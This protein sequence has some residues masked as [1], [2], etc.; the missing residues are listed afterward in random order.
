[1]NSS[2]ERHRNSISP[3]E[4]EKYRPRS[5]PEPEH[6]K[7][8]KEEKDCHG[9]DGE[10]SD[11]DLVVDDASED[12]VSPPNGTASP[13]ENGLEKMTNKKEHVGPHSPRSGTSSNASTPSTKKMEEKP[14]TPISKSVTPTSGGSG[15]GSGGSAG[16]GAGPA[17][18]ALKPVVKPPSLA[19]QY[20]HYLGGAGGGGGGGPHDLAAAAAAAAYG[21]AALHNNLPLNAYAAAARPPGPPLVGYEQMR[22]PPLGPAQMAG[23]PGG[24]PAYSFH[25]SAEGQMQPVPF[26]PDALIG[27]GI[28]RH[29]RQINTLSHGEGGVRRHHFQT[30]PS[31]STRGQ[32]LCQGVGHQSARLQVAC[33][34]VGLSATRQLHPVGETVAGRADADSGRGG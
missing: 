25:V 11:Q 6:K 10:K 8:K 18:A 29:A 27:P 14:T 24:K 34:A 17:G 33:V 23:I 1:I 12:P 26:P 13:R 5:P 9:S 22:A 28:P 16:G 30:R 21:A 19:A 2:E 7:M 20:P 31:T 15:G 32:G 3:A 4:R